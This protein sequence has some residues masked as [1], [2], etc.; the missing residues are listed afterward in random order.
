MEGTV[1]VEGADRQLSW[2]Q[3]VEQKEVHA[4]NVG[5][6]GTQEAPLSSC[7]LC[8]RKPLQAIACAGD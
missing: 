5:Q 1:Q 7:S 6:P 8:L 4:G 2:H 3:K